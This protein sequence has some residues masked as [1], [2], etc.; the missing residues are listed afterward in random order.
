MPVS[1]LVKPV[2]AELAR[3][4]DEINRLETEKAVY[5]AF[6]ELS[7][8]N[9]AK[10]KPATARKRDRSKEK[11]VPEEKLAELHGYLQRTIPAGQAFTSGDLEGWQGFQ[12]LGLAAS[13]ITGALGQL[14]AAGKVAQVG[15]GEYQGELTGRR[16]KVWRVVA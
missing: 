4:V 3:V 6:L 16:T 10:A 1:N 2:Q 11:A 13:R 5:E 15:R 9:G 14:A 7:K 8:A 12:E